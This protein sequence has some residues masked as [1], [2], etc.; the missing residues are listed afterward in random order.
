MADKSKRT[1]KINTWKPTSPKQIY[2]EKDDRVFV[3]HFD[4]IFQ[5][6]KVSDYNKFAIRKGSY[7]NQ[8]GIICD[9]TNFFINNYDTDNELLNVYLKIK[10]AVDKD[11]IFNKENMDAY[12]SFIYEIMFTD[13]IIEKIVRMVEENYLDDIECDSDDKKRKYQKNEKKHLESLEF[14]NQHI[15]ILLCISF[16]MKIMCPAMLHYIAIA[17]IKLEKESDYI[18]RFYR[19]LFDIFSVVKKHDDE[20]HVTDDG[21]FFIKNAA[22][23]YYDKYDDNTGA[24]VMSNVSDSV[25]EKLREEDHIRLGSRDYFANYNLYNKL[26][27]Y[28]KAKVNE[29]YSN[30]SPIFDQ[31]EIFGV[32][33]YSVVHSFVRRVL[34]SENMVKY[35]FNA[36]W[37]AKQKKYKENIIGFNKT[38]IKYQL[39]YFLK[40]QYSKNLTEI[41]NAKNTD[42]LSGADKMLM[43]LSKIDEG[44]TIM[45]DINIPTTIK[46]L[47]RRFNIEIS[48]AEIDYY[49]KNHVPS[50]IQIQLVHSYYAKYFGSYRDLMLCTRRDYVILMLLLKKKLMI[51]LGYE[52]DEGIDT[53]SYIKC[54]E[55][56][57]ILRK[58]MGENGEVFGDEIV[59]AR[60]IA[61]MNDAGFVGTIDEVKEAIEMDR[62]F[63]ENG[64]IIYTDINMRPVALPYI[65]CGN[66]GDQI[67]TRVIRNIKFTEKVESSYTFQKLQEENHKYLNFIKQ[68]YDMAL[69]SSLI[70][71]RFTYVEYEHPELLGQEITYSDNKIADEILFFLAS[72]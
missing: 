47:K 3:C 25:V 23:E 55:V 35:K 5:I 38:I 57:D 59:D 13:T 12:I 51:E 18:Y 50:Q 41:T 65:I 53:S 15:K 46:F 64:N 54:K 62:Y 34:I 1:S 52:H 29:C 63:D 48:E 19:P 7:E 58:D 67:N 66:L 24:L 45:S 2:V 33:I 10:F 61:A 11:K 36:T 6:D 71:T 39:L 27:V 31:Q 70:N 69:I 43:N 42:G 56:I 28:V 32:D 4:K 9:Y 68:N 8:L 21:Y 17:G 26:F 22:T 30:N 72:I 44:I 49:I 16:G 60:I 40:E 20:A 37:D 14:T